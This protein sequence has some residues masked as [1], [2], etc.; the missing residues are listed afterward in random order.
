MLIFIVTLKYNCAIFIE[1]KSAFCLV[2]MITSVK[3][4]TH[5]FV[6]ALDFY[7]SVVRMLE[8]NFPEILKKTYII[9]GIFVFLI[10]NI[11]VHIWNKGS[12]C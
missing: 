7:I 2:M 1:Y 12:L 8:D 6:A 11:R 9:N 3:Y 4:V 10:K 5:I